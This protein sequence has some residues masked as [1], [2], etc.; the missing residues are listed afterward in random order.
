LVP[1]ASTYSVMILNLLKE[2]SAEE[3]DH[4]FS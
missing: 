3:A 2:G 1:N 4:M